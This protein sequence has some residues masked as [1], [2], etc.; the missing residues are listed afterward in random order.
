METSARQDDPADEHVAER[1]AVPGKHTEQ[2]V[3][4]GESHSLP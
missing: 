1:M 3:H 2:E 4:G